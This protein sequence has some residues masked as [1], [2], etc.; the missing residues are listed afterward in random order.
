MYLAHA[1]VQDLPPLHVELEQITTKRVGHVLRV[2]FVFRGRMTPGPSHWTPA[3]PEA[4]F[5]TT[6][7]RS[8]NVILTSVD[9][10]SVVVRY[11]CWRGDR[12]KPI[13]T[14]R[15]SRPHG[16]NSFF[17]RAASAT[18]LIDTGGP[19]SRAARAR[20][21]RAQKGVPM[22][23]ARIFA[24]VICFAASACARSVADDTLESPL[25]TSRQ[26]EFTIPFTV[27]PTQSPNKMP[28]KAQLFLSTD[29]DRWK[30][31]D[32]VSPQRGHFQFRAPGDGEWLFCVRTID[33]RGRPIDEGKPKTELRVLVDT[34]HPSLSISAKRF[35]NTNTV[36]VHW[37]AR[38]DNIKPA[39]I[40]IQYRVVGTPHWQSV[41]IDRTK[42]R[43]PLIQADPVGVPYTAM[44]GPATP[45][46]RNHHN[47]TTGQ[48]TLGAAAGSEVM[49][50]AEIS[51]VAGNRSI[52]KAIVPP[53]VPAAHTH[54]ISNEQTDRNHP[55]AAQWRKDGSRVWPPNQVS[56]TPFEQ[57]SPTLV[58]TAVSRPKPSFTEQASSP[59]TITTKQ[60]DSTRF[61]LAYNAGTATRNIVKVD[62]WGTADG[63]DTWNNYG[64]DT[65]RQSPILVTVPSAG[66]YGFR[67]VV[68]SSAN[69]H[70]TL[71]QRGEAPQIW[72]SVVESGNL[73]ARFNTSRLGIS[74]VQVRR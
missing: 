19:C 62:L 71:P 42:I 10:L 47:S 48:V 38:D 3:G 74:D 13:P 53:A 29:G 27:T 40:K 59:T 56:Q 32:R 50:Q 16:R 46:D 72:I 12:G 65:D 8:G 1:A 33:H 58:P 22:R 73:S 70:P 34:I 17:S 51:D 30:L 15:F 6:F 43:N 20:G 39:S 68:Q 14:P 44:H 36:I 66:R 9:S 28:T 23:Q 63:G 52:S 45:D 18:D 21:N 54:P 64:S 37:Q 26:Y 61:D 67:I 24:V 7:T 35:I 60:V 25:V 69:P 4:S 5:S 2:D 57:T 55:T 41:L 11:R 31:V 49:I